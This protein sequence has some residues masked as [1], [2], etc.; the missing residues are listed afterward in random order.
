MNIYLS[1]SLRSIFN[2]KCDSHR[3]FGKTVQVIR[4]NINFLDVPFYS[5][6]FHSVLLVTE[7]QLNGH[8]HARTISPASNKRNDKQHRSDRFFSRARLSETIVSKRLTKVSRWRAGEKWKARG[9][10][11]VVSAAALNDG[12]LPLALCGRYANS[13]LRR[14]RS[15]YGL[16]IESR[17]HF[18]GPLWPH[19][20]APWPEAIREDPNIPNGMKR[21]PRARTSSAGER[22]RKVLVVIDRPS[23]FRWESLCRE[24]SDI[25]ELQRPANFH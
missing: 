23:I 8:N 2:L 17:W 6:L 22:T 4:D 15:R 3:W 7:I 12:H 14:N 20:F 10:S 1:V 11:T 18:N 16:F 21:A 13:K 19:S 24:L 5:V 25:L 9:R